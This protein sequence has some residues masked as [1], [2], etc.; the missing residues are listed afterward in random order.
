MSTGEV[1]AVTSMA[2]ALR[3]CAKTK[4]CVRERG[5]RETRE[6][7]GMLGEVVDLY[8]LRARCNL[9]IATTASAQM[10]GSEAASPAVV[11]SESCMHKAQHSTAQHWRPLISFSIFFL[12]T[13]DDEAATTRWYVLH[14]YTAHQ[15]LKKSSSLR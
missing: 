8:K 6:R 15:C 12:V 14:V 3:V 7:G 10:A 9:Q 5:S 2:I 1:A 4:E 13:T 11:G